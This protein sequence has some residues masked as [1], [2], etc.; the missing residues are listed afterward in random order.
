M[1]TISLPRPIDG[2]KTDFDNGYTSRVRG[3]T[4]S[5]SNEFQLLSIRS[6]QVWELGE[7]LLGYCYSV[8]PILYETILY[9]RAAKTAEA[10][11]NLQIIFE[12]RSYDPG[13]YWDDPSGLQDQLLRLCNK[14][15][16]DIQSLITSYISQ[17]YE[18][19]EKVNEFVDK[20]A[21]E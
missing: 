3:D 21:D 10:K 13:Q 6:L 4:M 9:G 20:K 19:I 5:T 15:T 8:T 11:R 14:G 2:K 7:L 16:S 12:T 17:T 1:V 18:E